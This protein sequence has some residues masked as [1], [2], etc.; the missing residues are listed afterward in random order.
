M[1]RENYLRLLA[2]PILPAANPSGY[3]GCL[4]TLAN[5]EDFPPPLGLRLEG[6]GTIT[7]TWR[8]AERLVEAQFERRGRLVVSAW[9]ASG[10]SGPSP[11][12]N[13]H[14]ALRNSLA[15]CYGSAKA[16]GH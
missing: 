2:N 16:A 9:N 10:D 4:R 12:A 3:D 1:S 5:L 13:I 8:R 6:D 11:H 15:W 14:L 7:L